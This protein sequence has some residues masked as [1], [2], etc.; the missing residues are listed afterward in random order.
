MNK[1]AHALVDAV[2]GLG[3]VRTGR[4]A[5]RCVRITGDATELA[6]RLDRVQEALEALDAA[7]G[8]GQA[9][10]PPSP[11]H[12]P[13]RLRAALDGLI[14]LCQV[15]GTGLGEVDAIVRSALGLDEGDEP[16]KRKKEHRTLP[17]FAPDRLKKRRKGYKM[18]TSILP[19]RPGEA[20][21]EDI[22][23][24]VGELD[25]TMAVAGATVPNSERAF[26]RMMERKFPPP[27]RR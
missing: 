23:K 17:A 4:P 14:R 21:L 6:S 7:G 13:A 16:A 20:S 1:E 19:D 10:A 8:L 2:R 5:P 12:D 9:D 25:H 27:A 18:R 11:A 24:I 22:R 3:I 26:G 15:K